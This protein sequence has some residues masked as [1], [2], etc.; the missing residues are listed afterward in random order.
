M[1]RILVFCLIILVSIV[2]CIARENEGIAEIRIGLKSPVAELDDPLLIDIKKIHPEGYN[3]P[4][5]AWEALGGVYAQ[6]GNGLWSMAICHHRNPDKNTRNPWY[7][8]PLVRQGMKIDPGTEIENMLRVA[9]KTEVR[10]TMVRTLVVANPNDEYILKFKRHILLKHIPAPIC[11]PDMESI[12]GLMRIHFYE[13]FIQPVS[14]LS[15]LETLYTVTPAGVFTL[16]IRPNSP[17]YTNFSKKTLQDR[18]KLE[19]ELKKFK[20]RNPSLIAKIRYS[21]NMLHDGYSEVAMA[22]LEKGDN[23]K[24]MQE[25]EEKRKLL[26]GYIELLEKNGVMMKFVP[27]QGQEKFWEK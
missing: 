24:V 8:I 10:F 7:I 1:L 19:V 18:Q 12:I 21:A 22:R 11:P 27:L 6:Q 25:F 20:S 3:S 15:Q 26:Q 23:S 13:V 2:P 4:M 16:K 17:L 5:E 14:A 9:D